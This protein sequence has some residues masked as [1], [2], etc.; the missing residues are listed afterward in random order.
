MCGSSSKETLINVKAKLAAL[1]QK[2]KFSNAI[3]EQQKVLNK[4]KLQQ[5]L[6]ETIAEETVCEEALQMD[7]RPFAR[8]DI[9]LPK[10]TPE[11]LIVS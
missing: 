1:K 8:D 6:S 7:E 5:E 10:E 2:I 4:L 11:Q 3:D 9:E